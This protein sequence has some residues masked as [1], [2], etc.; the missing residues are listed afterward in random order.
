MKIRLRIRYTSSIPPHRDL[1]SYG[2]FFVKSNAVYMNIAMTPTFIWRADCKQDTLK[3]IKDEHIYI[4]LVA[5]LDDHLMYEEVG[6]SLKTVAPI[7]LPLP[8][9]CV[10]RYIKNRNA[11]SATTKIRRMCVYW[12]IFSYRYPWIRCHPSFYLYSH[13]GSVAFIP[14][15]RNAINDDSY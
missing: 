10:F 11:K 3:L 15:T 9:V 12:V 7:H 2:I 14:I 5:T 8:T 13:C 6:N 4:L 1:L